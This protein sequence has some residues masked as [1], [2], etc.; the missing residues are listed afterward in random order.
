M[1]TRRDN[2]TKAEIVAIAAIETG[3]PVLVEAREIIA[4]FHAMI[5]TRRVEPLASRIAR[6]PWS[7]HW[8]MTSDETRQRCEQQSSRPGQT[9]RPRARSPVSSSSNPNVRQRKD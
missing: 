6:L 8:Q 4:D 2:L 7:S 9:A 3:V 1:A 5:R